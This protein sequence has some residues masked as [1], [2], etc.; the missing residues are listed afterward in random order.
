MRKP[1]DT[2]SAPSLAELRVAAVLTQEELAHRA[3][4]GLST[5]TNL[6]AGGVENPR[7]STVRALSEVIGVT[8]QLVRQSILESHR[9]AHGRDVVR[10]PG[11]GGSPLPA[12][13]SP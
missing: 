10:E 2:L 11:D 7:P 6:E 8:P 9:R 4:L 13:G 3:D 5:I 12:E 1:S